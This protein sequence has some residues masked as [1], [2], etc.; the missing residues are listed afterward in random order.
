MA[1]KK[2]YT[3]YAGGVSDR[4]FSKWYNNDFSY[5]KNGVFK[6]FEF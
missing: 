1:E 3:N 4:R 5:W 2:L 6:K